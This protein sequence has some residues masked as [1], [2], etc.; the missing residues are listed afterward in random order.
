MSCVSVL[1]KANPAAPRYLL[2]PVAYE[3]PAAT[4]VEWSLIIEDPVSTRVYDTTKMALVREPGRVEFYANGEWADR[5]PR[6]VQTALIRSYENS[7][8]ILGV[9]DR[10]SL[11]GGTFAL[12]TDIRAMHAD[13]SEGKPSAAFA[14]FARLTNARGQVI[15]ARLFEQKVEAGED[16]V[17]SIA[18]A[19]DKAVTAA[20]SDL[21]DWSI[22]EAQKAHDAKKKATG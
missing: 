13:Y 7:G 16:T 14:V 11:P 6:L 18:A 15:S 3:Q 22:A 9:G 8:R 1:P 2:E 10:I 5:A 21:I 19:F 12:Q 17:P 20:L 4:P